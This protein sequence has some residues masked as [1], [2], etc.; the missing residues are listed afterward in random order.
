M[1]VFML[2]LA[3][4]VVHVGSILDDEAPDLLVWNNALGIRCEQGG[5]TYIVLQTGTI[6]REQCAGTTVLN[7][8]TPDEQTVNSPG[9][10]SC[11]DLRERVAAS[12]LN[13]GMANR[14]YTITAVF[15]E[16]D[17]EWPHTA[18]LVRTEAR[19]CIEGS[20]LGSGTAFLTPEQQ[21]EH[22]V[23]NSNSINGVLP[24]NWCRQ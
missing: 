22:V 17:P 13:P 23:F 16:T 15:K 10:L 14:N 7:Q 5:E 1:L 12:C 2:L 24:I 8:D 19:S 20:R 18:T 11:G 3:C 9:D 21:P 6:G 4:D